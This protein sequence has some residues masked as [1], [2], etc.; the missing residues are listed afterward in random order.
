MPITKRTKPLFRLINSTTVVVNRPGVTTLVNGR[1][2]KGTPT[3]HDIEAN[4]QPLK[5]KEILLMDESDRTKEWIVL[6]VDPDQDIRPAK[7]GASGWEADEVV[8][9]GL[10]YKVMKFQLYEMGVLDHK[11]V[12]AART[13]ISAVV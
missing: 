12:Y 7:E 10:S 13:P 11:R 5:N 8:W 9:G 4:V 2:V 6:Y 1:P 3:Q